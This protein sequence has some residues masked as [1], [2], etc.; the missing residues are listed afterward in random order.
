MPIHSRARRE[1]L[2]LVSLCQ[3]VG[4]VSRRRV[5]ILFFNESSRCFVSLAHPPTPT[6]HCHP[7]GCSAL[8]LSSSVIF[9]TEP[10]WAALVSG[11]FLKETMGPN[12]LV[13]AGV[14][15]LA[16]LVAQSEQ[17]I[18]LLGV[19]REDGHQRL[20]RSQSESDAD[21]D[22]VDDSAVGERDSFPLSVL[23]EME[24][25]V[26]ESFDVSTV[27]EYVLP[28]GVYAE[29]PSMQER[30]VNELPAVRIGW[31]GSAASE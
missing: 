19:G 5:Y 18:E 28:P 10:L 1:R 12:A 26:E 6:S 2:W 8:L 7:F 16:C 17:I 27:Q 15:L 30:G 21:D 22:V 31:F 11:V 20:D 24:P 4:A 9:S 23:D 13:G 14:I 3:F 29:V 25:A